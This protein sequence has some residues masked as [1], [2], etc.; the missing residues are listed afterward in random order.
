VAKVRAAMKTQKIETIAASGDAGAAMVEIL[1]MNK[2][3]V[4]GRAEMLEGAPEEVAG[5]LAK[6]LA[7][8]GLV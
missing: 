5:K 6:M 4:T 8:R 1:E 2:P 7:D 3:V